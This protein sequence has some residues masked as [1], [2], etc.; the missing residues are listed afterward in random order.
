MLRYA[1]LKR[2]AK[3]LQKGHEELARQLSIFDSLMT[4][5][6][7]YEFAN[8]LNV[9]LLTT[10]AALAREESRGGHYREDFP[11]RDHSMWKKHIVFQRGEDRIEEWI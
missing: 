4:K 3:G 7:E 10:T 2:N 1:G 8:L 6:E 9:A 11:E 5:R